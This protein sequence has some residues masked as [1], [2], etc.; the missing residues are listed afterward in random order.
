MRRSLSPGHAG[1]LAVKLGAR[2]T[3]IMAA[4]VGLAGVVAGALIAFAGQLA[5]QRRGE[6]DRFDSLLLEQFAMIIAISEDFRNRVWEE[7]NQVA[8]DVVGKWDLGRTGLR[9]LDSES[10]PDRRRSTLR[11]R[12]LTRR[13]RALER[14]GGP[15]PATRRPSTAH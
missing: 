12:T 15:V 5:M 4:W 1:R 13:A 8:S 2:E 9:K 3:W 11:L 14:R 6:R 10:C 7:R